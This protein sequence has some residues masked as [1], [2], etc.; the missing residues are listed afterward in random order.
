MKKLCFYILIFSFLNYIGCYSYRNVN[1]EIL[2]TSDLGEPAGVV[3]IITNDEKKIVVHDGIYE[4]VGDTLHAKGINKANTTVYGQPIVVK[5]A[6]N[7]IRSVK[8]EELDGLAI[9]GCAI[10]IAAL[11]LFIAGIIWEGSRSI[12]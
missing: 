9:A 11:A 1:K 12:H 5:I 4:L 10:G 8:I 2:Y 6:L 7:D 3:T